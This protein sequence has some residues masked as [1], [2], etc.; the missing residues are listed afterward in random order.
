MV[1][2]GGEQEERLVEVPPA[3]HGRAQQGSE[4]PAVAPAQA[5]DVEGGQV[6]GGDEEAGEPQQLLLDLGQRLG[7]RGGEPADGPGRRGRVVVE[8]Q[9]GAV[10]NRFSEGP[11]SSVT[12]PRSRNRRSVQMA[13]R[14]MLRM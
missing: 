6:E 9:V 3:A 1:R 12:T 10:G 11:A 8:Q 7:I 4:G 13:G 2:R 14:S 5:P